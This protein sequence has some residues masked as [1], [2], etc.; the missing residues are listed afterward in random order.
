MWERH[1]FNTRSQRD[2]ET[3]DQ[4]VTDLKTKA[5]TCEFGELKDS[6]IRDRIVC[7]IR[8]DKTRS[9]LLREPDLTLQRAIDIC[10]ANEAMSSQMKSFTSDQINDLRTCH[11]RNTFT[12][13]TSPK[14]VL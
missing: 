2:G 1:M 13:Q 8:C 4:Y 14:A 9:R 3:T 12:A 5:Q 10:R 6:L 11:P 7:G